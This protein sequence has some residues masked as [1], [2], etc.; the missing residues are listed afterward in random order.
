MFSDQE[1]QTCLNILQHLSNSPDSWPPSSA[2]QMKSLIAKIY[3]QG[4]KQ[5][6]KQG[7]LEKRKQDQA[8]DEQTTLFQK[9]HITNH[10]TLNPVEQQ[11]EEKTQE[12]KSFRR[13]YCCKKKY[14]QA[15]HFYHQLCEVCAP[16]NYKNRSQQTNLKGRI[17]L[18]TGGR[19][20]IGYALVLKMLRDG[21]EVHVT[22][23]FP[24]DATK[25]YAQEDDFEQWKDRLHIYGLD[26]RMIGQVEKFIQHLHQTLPHLDIIANNAAQT[27]QRPIGF[28]QH[29]LD[30]EQQKLPTQQQKLLGNAPVSYTLPE[31]DSEQNQLQLLNKHFPIGQLDADGQQV[32]LRPQNSWTQRLEEVSTAEMIETHLVNTFSPFILNSQL[33]P[34]LLKS[35]YQR[36]FIVNVSAMEGQFNRPSKTI[37]HPHTNMAKAGLNMLTRTAADDYA[38]AG[39]YMTS[40]DTGW[41]TEENPHPLKTNIR[42]HKHFIPPLDAIDGAARLYAPI[43]EGLE[44]EETPYFGVF[45]KDYKPYDW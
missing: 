38:N 32:D 6:R 29:L 19:I 16:F 42:K 18:V 40:V 26:L 21:A 45:L 30:Y 24:N 37:Y 7:A 12:Y 25:R 34:L 9:N 13:C 41:I 8:L 23:R 15:H 39:I 33:K 22:T 44:N 31:L 10:P 4:R 28:Y 17:A 2:K 14:N 5:Q 1:W 35:P 43:V 20:K 11:H 36:R 27:V 3:K